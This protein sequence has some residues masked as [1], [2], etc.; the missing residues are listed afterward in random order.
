[1]QCKCKKGYKSTWDN[2]C[3]NCRTPKEQ[4][5]HSAKMDEVMEYRITI[6]NK[7]HGTKGEYIG[8]GSPMGNPF[9]VHGDQDREQAIAGY[10]NW[11]T[12]CIDMQEPSIIAELNRLAYKLIDEKELTLICFCAPKACHGNVIADVLRKVLY[13]Y[14]NPNI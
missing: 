14:C 4:K 7:H 5:L 2:L 3:A 11:L 6:G 12:K 1:M 10:R 13:D 9:V 8:R